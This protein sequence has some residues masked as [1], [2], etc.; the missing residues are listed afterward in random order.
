MNA[1]SKHGKKQQPLQRDTHGRLRMCA[2]VQLLMTVSRRQS[3][4]GKKQIHINRKILKKEQ[5]KN[6]P[7]I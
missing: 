4:E 2:R 7:I 5:E 1:T 6:F 3:D